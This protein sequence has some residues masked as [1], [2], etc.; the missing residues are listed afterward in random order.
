M[1]TSHTNP[2]YQ[3]TGLAIDRPGH[4]IL[5]FCWYRT[6]AIWWLLPVAKQQELSAPWLT[7][8]DN[9]R[10]VRRS[11]I[12]PPFETPCRT[13]LDSEHEIGENHRKGQRRV[14][15]E[16]RGGGIQG[17]RL[18]PKGACLFW[19]RVGRAAEGRRKGAR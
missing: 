14:S 6:T 18:V 3:Q 19:R 5:I 11:C 4:M 15:G 12:D 13:R 7:E 16:S 9:R 17:L 10:F 1:H 8:S 2:M